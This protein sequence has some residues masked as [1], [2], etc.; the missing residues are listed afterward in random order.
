[1]HA[2]RVDFSQKISSLTDFLTAPVHMGNLLTFTW[3]DKCDGRPQARVMFGTGDGGGAD[4]GGAGR[5]HPGG[6]H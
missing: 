5:Q 4:A 1:M 2:A 6:W 3:E